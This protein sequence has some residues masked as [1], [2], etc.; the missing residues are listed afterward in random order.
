MAKAQV[1]FA[2]PVPS[3]GG[4]LDSDAISI[5]ENTDKLGIVLDYVMG[6]E[7]GI[8][9]SFNWQDTN[10]ADW[11]VGGDSTA[12]GTNAWLPW[13]RTLG[14]SALGDLTSAMGLANALQATMNAHAADAGEHGAG[15]DGVNFPDATPIAT[16]LATLLTLTGNLLTAYAAHN[17][18]ALLGAAWAFHNAQQLGNVLTSVIAP[19]SLNESITRLN[20]LKAMYNGHEGSAAS[21]TVGGTHTEVAGDAEAGTISVLIPVPENLLYAGLYR[22]RLSLIGA[23]AGTGTVSGYFVEGRRY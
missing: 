8:G 12:P 5:V 7:D 18:D 1:L 14:V 9:V 20:D 2:S 23:I 17:A 10:D 19:L 6:A 21:H 3:V 13:E 16:N 11:R 22:I 15:A 4:V